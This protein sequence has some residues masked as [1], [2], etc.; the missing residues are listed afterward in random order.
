[1]LSSFTT[2]L[3][4]TASAICLVSPRIADLTRFCQKWRNRIA[5][6]KIRHNK[7]V[8]GGLERRKSY[9]SCDVRMPRQDRRGSSV[10]WLEHGYYRA[11]RGRFRRWLLPVYYQYNY[12]Q[13]RCRKHWNTTSNIEKSKHKKQVQAIAGLHRSSVCPQSPGVYPT[14]F[15][16]VKITSNVC[17]QSPC[18]YPTWFQNVKITSNRS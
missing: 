17:P 7:A 2:I 3:L 1:M 13:K 11:K 4:L 16:N 14:W 6:G 12:Y 10:I 9:D 15:Q 5:I 8:C 18:V